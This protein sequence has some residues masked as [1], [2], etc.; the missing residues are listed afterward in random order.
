[1]LSVLIGRTRQQ[2]MKSSHEVMAS[3]PNLLQVDAFNDV[4]QTFSDT[5]LHLQIALRVLEGVDKI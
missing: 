2:F 4:E 1:M 5:D 3:A